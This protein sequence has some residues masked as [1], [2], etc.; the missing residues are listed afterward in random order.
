LK[1]LLKKHTYY[2]INSKTKRTKMSFVASRMFGRRLMAGAKRIMPRRNMTTE[3]GNGGSE[4]KSFGFSNLGEMAME[5]TLGWL[6][7]NLFH[8]VF[9][10]TATHLVD[11]KYYTYKLGQHAQSQAKLGRT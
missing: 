1:I 10:V 7:S 2:R 9:L 6:K 3:T 11:H 5:K 8:A 4:K